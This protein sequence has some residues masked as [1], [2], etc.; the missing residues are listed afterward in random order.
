MNRCLRTF[1]ATSATYDLR[2]VDM[3]IVKT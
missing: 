3:Y 2:G 1:N